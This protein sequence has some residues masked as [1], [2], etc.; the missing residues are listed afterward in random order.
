LGGSS[1]GSPSLRHNSSASPSRSQPSPTPPNR[2]PSRHARVR[3][4]RMVESR[5]TIR[6]PVMRC[7]SSG[8]TGAH[9]GCK[10]TT[11][12]S[13]RHP[14]ASPAKSPHATPKRLDGPSTPRLRVD[15][16]PA[17]ARAI[18]PKSPSVRIVRRHPD[19]ELATTTVDY[20][21]DGHREHAAA[22]PSA[23][24]QRDIGEANHRRAIRPA[25][26]DAQRAFDCMT[27]SRS[28]GGRGADWGDGR[29]A[30]GSADWT[31]SRLACSFRSGCDRWFRAACRQRQPAGMGARHR[32]RIADRG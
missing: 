4:R 19:S 17:L 26:L 7:Q 13:T 18:A 12:R 6:S 5:R 29:R 30:S 22:R 10:W 15:L 31:R 14:V 25:E 8:Q 28:P 9:Q 27:G 1:S 16:T 23:S 21:S 32:F 11:V 3:H 24:S 20:C 2:R